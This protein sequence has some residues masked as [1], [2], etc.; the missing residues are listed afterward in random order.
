MKLCRKCQKPGHIQSHCSNMFKCGNC[1]GGHPT[2][3]C[4][5]TKGQAIPVKC[6][7]CGEGH[8]PT[9]R[10]CPVKVA[11]VNEA[12]Q[13]LAECPTYHRIP[14]HFRTSISSSSSNT[15]EKDGMDP[16][17]HSQESVIGLD[18]ALE[19]AEATPE[20]T[21]SKRGPGRPKGS[22]TRAKAPKPPVIPLACQRS[23]RFQLASQE[24]TQEEVNSKRR[25][26]G[27]PADTMDEQPDDDDW[28]N[29]QLNPT[30]FSQTNTQQG[31]QE[32]RLSQFITE[33]TTVNDPGSTPDPGEPRMPQVGCLEI[34][35]ATGGTD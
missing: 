4:P 16:V 2:W 21:Q 1:A 3:E 26:T 14:L 13:A 15:T 33:V 5:S 22:R 11:A 27:E 20:A 10:D 23:T 18:T 35:K 32:H 28:F 24:A 30:D 25:R 17:T 31:S 8:R 7:N 9:I 34:Q 29:I 19:E 12:K 6:A